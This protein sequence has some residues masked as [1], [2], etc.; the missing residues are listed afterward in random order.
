V[1]ITSSINRARL[2]VECELSGLDLREVQDLVDE[3]KQVGSGRI[4]AT[5]R[6]GSLLRPEARRIGDHHLGQTNNGVER[7]A[8]LVAHAGEELRLVLARRFDVL[9]QA[10]QLVAHPIDLGRQRAQLVAIDNMNALVEVA[11]RKPVE[12][13]LDLLDRANQRPRNSIAEP[14]SERDAGKCERND[15]E[16]CVGVRLGARFDSRDHVRLGL[17]D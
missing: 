5:Q 12:A 11:G 2:G 3:A 1:P 4:H 6:L 8:Q 7:R 16:L 17:V 14:E 13:C 15:D 9:I 10:S